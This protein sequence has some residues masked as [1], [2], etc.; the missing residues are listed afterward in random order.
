MTSPPDSGP[1]RLRGQAGVP[2]WRD[3]SSRKPR[4]PRAKL[5]PQLLASHQSTKSIFQDSD[6][7]LLEVFGGG[8][9]CFRTDLSENVFAYTLALTMKG[10]ACWHSDAS[11]EEKRLTFRLQSSR[12]VFDADHAV[13][14]PVGMNQR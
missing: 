6:P 1:S 11:A 10:P 8:S 14:R 2:S 13:G 7:A 5:S 12:R 9:V 3:S 4:R